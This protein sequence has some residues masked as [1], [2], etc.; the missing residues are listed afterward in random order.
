[1]IARKL[2]K[3]VPGFPKKHNQ[4]RVHRES[5]KREEIGHRYPRTKGAEDFTLIKE[6]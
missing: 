3:W 5:E 1:M 6:R 2:S 4:C